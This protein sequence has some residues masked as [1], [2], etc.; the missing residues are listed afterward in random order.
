VYF[1]LFTFLGAYGYITADYYSYLEF[2]QEANGYGLN[3]F[4]SIEPAYIWL[5]KLLN[6]NYFL[7]RFTIMILMYYTLYICLLKTKLNNF[8]VLFFYSIF[9]LHTNISGRQG[10]ANSIF[11]LGALLIYTNWKSLPKLILGL[12]LAIVSLFLHKSSLLFFPLLLFY[13]LS[14]KRKHI[15]L[16]LLLAPLFIYIEN[17]LLELIISFSFEAEVRGRY[18]LIANSIYEGRNIWWFL[19]AL[20]QDIST[21]LILL[22]EIFLFSKHNILKDKNLKCLYK[23]LFGAFYISLLLYFLE[24]DSNV[25]F[26]RVLVFAKMIMVFLIPVLL[27]YF[28]RLKLTIL[29]L[30]LAY[31]LSTNIFILGVSFSNLK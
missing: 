2:V 22:L 23:L 5:S 21:I 16:L 3:I 13:L 4:T 24:I 11:I 25:I 15:I 10:L 18:Q 7:F 30:A 1:L 28:K 9:C 14:L 8:S 19:I 31:L 12:F 27:F 6:G 20:I 17:K 29:I 26:R